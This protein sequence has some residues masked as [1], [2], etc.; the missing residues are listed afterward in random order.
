M[1][2]VLYDGLSRLPAFQPAKYGGP[3]PPDVSALRKAIAS[4][5]GILFCTP[6]CAGTLPGT[7]KNL[8]DWRFRRLGTVSRLPGCL[9]RRRTGDGAARLRRRRHRGLRPVSA[10]PSGVTRSGRTAS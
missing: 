10:L 2:L 8:L 1:R 6:E 5:D 9:S 3:L 7:L 4:A